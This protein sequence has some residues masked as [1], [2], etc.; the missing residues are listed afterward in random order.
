MNSVKVL[1]NVV[2][3]IVLLSLAVVGVACGTPAIAGGGRSAGVT[4]YAPGDTNAYTINV[5]GT[6]VASIRPDVVEVQLGVEAIGAD[7]EQV[8]NQS[9]SR[10]EAVLAAIEDLGIADEDVQTI[11]YNMW[12]EQSYDDNGRPTDKLRYH[13]NHQVNVRLS[14]VAKTGELLEK[15][16]KAGAN[17]VGGIQFNVANPET[18]QSQAREAALQD[19]RAKAEELASGLGVRLGNVR[20]VTEYSSNYVPAPRMAMEEGL[21]GGSVP[22]ASGSFDV[23]VEVQVTFDIVQ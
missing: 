4:A 1:R 12:V 14:D 13:V 8:I 7:A 5:N 2:L 17:T 19:A 21:G 15:A 10:M 6:G 3:T 20:F 22:V 11:N 9:T 23:T 16:L 18:L